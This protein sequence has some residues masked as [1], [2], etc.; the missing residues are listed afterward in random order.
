MIV[1][2]L[3]PAPKTNNYEWFEREIKPHEPELRGFINK[4]VSELTDVD[5]VLQETYRRLFRVK[6]QKPI[7]Y[8]RG[9]LFTIAKNITRDLFRR[10]L[11][12]KT[13]PV[14]DIEIYDLEDD[15]HLHERISRIDELDILKEAIDT[16]PKRCQAVF[17][18]R[19]FEQLTY[20]E[21]A[22]RMNISVN[23]V[24][25]QLRKGLKRCHQYFVEK[26]IV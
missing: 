1:N 17:V 22:E 24:E 26:G 19:K 11:T 3:M 5:D 7:H 23:T 10:K 13:F 4:H 25:V 12:A 20:K 8:P 6:E 16:L 14:E 21:I 2:M 18:L 15:D 9:L